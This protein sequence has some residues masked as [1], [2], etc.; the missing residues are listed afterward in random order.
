MCGIAGLAGAV[1]RDEAQQRVRRMKSTLTRRGPDGE[2]V[3]T[4]PEAVLG[5]R[6][7]AIYD[8]SELGA[9]P[10]L[11]PD[12]AVGITFN[13][14]IYNFRELRVELEA[15]GYHF[16]SHT[17]TEVMLHG[18]DAWGLDKLLQRMRGMFAFGLWDDRKRTLFLVRDRLGVKPLL[19]SAQ[20]GQL[21]FASTARA[22]RAGGFAGEI[23]DLA[24]AEYLEWGYVTDER[25]IY[26]D[27]HKVGA[28]SVVEWSNGKLQTRTYWQPPTP[29]G[30]QPSFAEALKETERLFLSAVEKRLFADVPVGALLSGGIDSSLI[31][32][33]IKELGGDVTAFTVGTPGDPHDETADATDTAQRL[34][35][36]HEILQLTSN[37][38]PDLSELV[39][40]YAEPFACA[41]ALG[42]LR[43]SQA[44]RGSATVLLTGD[45][46]DDVFLGYP[47]H[48]HL[49]LAQKLARSLPGFVANGWRKSQDKLP[50]IGSLKRLN[51][52]MNYSTGGLGA[53][54][55]THDGL[56]AYKQFG[57]LGD[58]LA[59]V[60]LAQR[61]IEWSHVSGRNVLA[62]FLE[63]DR[64]GRFVG[65]FMTKVDGATMFH[66]LEARSPFLD[67]DLWEFAA[68]LSFET[69]M[70]GGRLKSL[71]RA[72]AAE[73]IG[74]RL[75]RGRKRGFTIPVNRW[76]VGRWRTALTE[77]LDNAIADREGWINSRA[78][79]K[80]L[81]VAAEKGWAPNQFWYIFV[82]ESWL[83]HEQDSA[84]E[85]TS[86][87]F[88]PE[89]AAVLG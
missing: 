47:E 23:D 15:A 31:C 53:V 9:Q 64:A 68:G 77:V 30:K 6:R 55:C 54:A 86:P 41:S 76:L 51:S 88:E 83:R 46:G 45:G 2:G 18:Y 22:L 43:V 60:S 10:M 80:Q 61:E 48:R 69:R 19:Y 81:N 28:A 73:K 58:R 57:M 20:N 44:V 49:L 3:K 26:R 32:W 50:R 11:S 87:V 1:D 29:N 82:L 40:A 36:R 78:V 5:H 12:G 35:I 62:E 79:V 21:A 37:S 34:G 42:M 71:L 38:E 75:A 70:H 13:G 56:P 17:D 66:S 84:M 89:G 65:E 16:K 74:E 8:L 63:Y 24:I 52:F 33:A 67:Q 7:L 4:W 85:I 14:A 27:V 25:S 39:S 59:G 72:L